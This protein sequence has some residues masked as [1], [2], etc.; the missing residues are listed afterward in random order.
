LTNIESRNGK[1]Y[2]DKVTIDQIGQIE[3]R[4]EDFSLLNKK[5]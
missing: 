2:T 5:I 3:A 4:G 1:F